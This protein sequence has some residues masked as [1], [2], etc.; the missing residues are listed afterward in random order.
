MKRQ[1]SEYIRDNIV[2]TTSGMN[3]RLPLMMTI[4]TLGVDNVLFAAD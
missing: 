2:V 4:Q 1:P 3:F